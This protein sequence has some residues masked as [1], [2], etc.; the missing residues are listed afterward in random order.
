MYDLNWDSQC[1]PQIGA[2]QGNS[3][4]LQSFLKSLKQ[5]SVEGTQFEGI[6]LKKKKALFCSK[7]VE[8]RRK[9]WEPL[10]L[11]SNTGY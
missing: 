11:L 4:V 10:A 2:H 9:A 5:P 3:L 7:S 1:R 8:I 6:N